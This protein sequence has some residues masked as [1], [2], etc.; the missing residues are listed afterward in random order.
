MGSDLFQLLRPYWRV[1]VSWGGGF[2]RKW[3]GTKNLVSVGK[4]VFLFVCF[5]LLEWDYVTGY[6]EAAL[7]VHL[8][9][10]H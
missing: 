9:K 3:E 10:G 2:T 1:V 8:G 4:G 6:L 5:G 7:L